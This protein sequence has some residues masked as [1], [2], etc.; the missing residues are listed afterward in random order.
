M[1]K[2]L[3][4]VG[5]LLLIGLASTACRRDYD[6]VPATAKEVFPIQDGKFRIYH[7][8]DTSYAS[9]TLE[10]ARTYYKRELTDGTETDL[11]DREVSVLWLHTSPDTLGTVD[12]PIYSW[13]FDELWTQYLGTEFAERIEGNTRKLVLRWPPYEGATWNGNLYNSLD[14]Q[15]YRYLNVDT[16]VVVRGKTYEHCVFVLQVPFRMPVEKIPG[17][18]P[19]PFFLIEHA[20][21]IYAP[22]IGKIVG[23]Y[24]YY[25]EQ[26]ISG[27]TQ[28][29]EDSRIYYEELVTHNY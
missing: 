19:P 18:P 12:A 17:N 11:L 25:E 24:K 28:I 7:V 13:D 6:P 10:D 29:D 8:I 20:Y 23:Y 4:L 9:T 2:H 16:T 26:V 27:N 14:V 15:T 22:K 3:K 21:E 1:M 5:F